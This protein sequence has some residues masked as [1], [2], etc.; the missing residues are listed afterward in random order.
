M[1]LRISMK[2]KQG[3]QKEDNKILLV[4]DVQYGFERKESTKKM[5]KR[6]PTF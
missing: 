6:L 1:E 5:Q 2:T 4:V 3:N